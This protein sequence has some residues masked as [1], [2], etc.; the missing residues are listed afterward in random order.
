MTN[1]P[2]TESGGTQPA[3]KIVF[4]PLP[5]SL[6]LKTGAN[7]FTFD[8]SIPVPVEIPVDAG[9]DALKTLT[10]EMIVAA[11]I[12]VICK[13]ADADKAGDEAAV[14]YRNFVL[15][16]KPDI[17]DEFK[18]AATAYLRNGSYGM[19]REVIASLRGLFPGSA[20][21]EKLDAALA[22]VGEDADY[23]EARRL[24]T[25][26]QEETGMNRLRKFLERRP[27][28]WNGWFLLGWALRRLKR[29]QDALSCFR[30]AL[31]AGGRCPDTYNEI[32]ICLME[33]GDY[34]SARRE[35]EAALS[36]DG[37]NTKIISNMAVLALKTG[38]DAE[39]R[40][41][42]RRVLDIDP[43]DP[44]AAKFFISD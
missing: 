24:I 18:A 1:G 37:T 32:A 12:R 23:R 31:N 8:P 7:G 30:K 44:L 40:S 35:L 2:Y 4:L 16:Y 26:G 29:W 39:A 19:A 33:T 34:E 43:D 3:K 14:Y 13:Y 36:S 6:S 22:G 15:A 11:M 27:D 41:L 5:E 38:R 42:F 21:A 20:D 17:L 10:I 9:P 28:S 25:D